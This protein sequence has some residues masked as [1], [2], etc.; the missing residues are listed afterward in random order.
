MFPI[1]PIRF[2]VTRTEVLRLGPQLAFGGA[3]IG[4]GLLNSATDPASDLHPA[5]SGKRALDT[6][7]RPWHDGCSR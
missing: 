6:F 2:Y 7:D 4:Q 5:D 3:G 1:G